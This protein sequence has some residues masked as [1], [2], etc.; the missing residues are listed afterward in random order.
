MEPDN[1]VSEMKTGGIDTSSN[2]DVAKTLTSGI[3]TREDGLINADN[4]PA[5]D[6]INQTI[7]EIFE[8]IDADNNGILE[9]HEM[10]KAFLYQPK[11]I[12]MVDQFPRLKLFLSPR[13]FEN[14]FVQLQTAIDGRITRNEFADFI[15]KNI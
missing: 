2:V 4:T 9:K 1:K 6:D 11:L 8:L 10:L 3:K 7:N 5:N 13:Q 12:K 14:Q 15:S